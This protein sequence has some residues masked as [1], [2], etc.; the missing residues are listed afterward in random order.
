LETNLEFAAW[1]K[2]AWTA[3]KGRQVS[4]GGSPTRHRPSDSDGPSPSKEPQLSANYQLSPTW[5]TAANTSSPRA[6]HAS[7]KGRQV[8]HGGR[9]TRH[10][11]SDSDGPSPYK[12]S[13]RN[14]SFRRTINCRR[15]G[16]PPL[17]LVAQE[18]FTPLRPKL[19]GRM[20]HGLDDSDIARANPP[21][22]ADNLPR[23][24]SWQST[25]GRGCRVIADRAQQDFSR[26]K[27][28]LKFR[29]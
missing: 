11:P 9:P 19:S 14:L 26:E 29:I 21:T 17:I 2:W 20:A 3:R 28:D 18:R 7:R 27:P 10:R 8:S 13:A 22:T 24:A 16:S 15:L 25:S 4:H 6:L 1:K 23:Y 12:D 5:I